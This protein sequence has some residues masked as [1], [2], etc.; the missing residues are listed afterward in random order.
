M[1]GGLANDDASCGAYAT[2]P[3]DYER[4]SM[5]LEPLLREYHGIVGDIKQK[6]DWNIPVGEYMLTEIDINK[7]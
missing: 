2:R 1:I 7:I 6:H 3:E 5:L 4:F